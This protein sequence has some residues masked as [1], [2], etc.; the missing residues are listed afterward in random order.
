MGVEVFLDVD[1][2]SGALLEAPAHADVKALSVLA[3]DQEVDVST[4]L[5][6]QRRQAIVVELGRTQVDVEVELESEAQQDAGQVGGVIDAR[7][8]HGAEQNRVGSLQL[9]PC[10]LRNR[11]AGTE[12][13]VGVDVVLL[14]LVVRAGRAQDLDRLGDDLCA[15]AVARQDGDVSRQVLRPSR[16]ACSAG[17]CRS[18]SSASRW[19]SPSSAATG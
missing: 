15:G 8:A 3:D 9:L 19:R 7:V 17:S 16:A 6:A 4:P 2:L 5:L 14:E 18:P 1:F 10:R 12:E 11:L 13:L